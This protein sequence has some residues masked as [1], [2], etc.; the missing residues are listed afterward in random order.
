[1]SLRRTGSSAR[2]L[3]LTALAIAAACLGAAV[4]AMIGTVACSTRRERQLR[5]SRAPAEPT[6]QDAAPPPSKPVSPRRGPSRDVAITAIT[7]SAAILGAVVGGGATYLSNREVTERQIRE[8]RQARERLDDRTAV[9]VARVMQT[10]LFLASA[11]L[12]KMA[13]EQRYF[14][15]RIPVS[16]SVTGRDLQLVAA[17]LDRAR[18]QL[19]SE[20]SAR[21]RYAD[22]VLAQHRGEP[23]EPGET[24]AMREYVDAAEAASEALD[25][26]AGGG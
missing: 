23:F 4:G 10:D 18:W 24:A 15:S 7:A 14:R 5:G 13:D 22:G 8:D 17:R 6:S 21:L 3:V 12:G 11:T 16:P 9:G 25:E 26:L 1:M 19:V 20:A 2:E